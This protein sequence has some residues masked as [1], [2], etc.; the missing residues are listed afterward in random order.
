MSEEQ[1]LWECQDQLNPHYSL[2]V[3]RT[4]PY[5]GLLTVSFK[6]DVFQSVEVPV[7]YD[8]AYGVDFGD[9]ELWGQLACKITQEHEEKHAG[10]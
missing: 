4:S 5:K 6:G 7:Q 1:V 10:S 9:M 2:K 8:A 3:I